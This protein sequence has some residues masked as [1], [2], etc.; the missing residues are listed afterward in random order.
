MFQIACNERPVASEAPAPAPAGCGLAFIECPLELR[1]MGQQA[2]RND[3]C[4]G[5][6]HGSFKPLFTA[7]MATIAFMAMNGP[8]YSGGNVTLVG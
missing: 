8:H 3:D 2:S 5:S 4:H 7:Q 1:G 6:L